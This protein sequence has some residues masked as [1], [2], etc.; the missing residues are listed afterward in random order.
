MYGAIGAE[1]AVAK[2][3]KDFRLS[4]DEARRLGAYR[5]Q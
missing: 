4:P 5:T 1:S 2:A 3:A